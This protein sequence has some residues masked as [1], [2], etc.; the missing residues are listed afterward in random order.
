MF[1]KVACRCKMAGCKECGRVVICSAGGMWL[2]YAAG[3]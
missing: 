1:G 3:L 2:W